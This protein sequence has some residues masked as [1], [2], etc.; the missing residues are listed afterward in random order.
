MKPTKPLN[1]FSLLISGLFLSLTLISSPSKAQSTDPNV[2]F[3]QRVLQ[4]GEDLPQNKKELLVS[5]SEDLSVGND[6]KLQALLL[7]SSSSIHENLIAAL[8]SGDDAENIV[9]LLGVINESDEQFIKFLSALR[10][11]IH[12]DPVKLE[13]VRNNMAIVYTDILATPVRL[14]ALGARLLQTSIL[15]LAI[16]SLAYSNYPD[17][18]ESSLYGD[19]MAFVPYY[20]GMLGMFVLSTANEVRVFFRSWRAYKQSLRQRLV[21]ERHLESF[22]D[23]VK[24]LK[25]APDLLPMIDRMKYFSSPYAENAALQALASYPDRFVNDM[26]YLSENP[27]HW[28]QLSRFFKTREFFRIVKKYDDRL[29]ETDKQTLRRLFREQGHLNELPI[30]IKEEQLNF[31]ENLM[32]EFNQWMETEGHQGF[33]NRYRRLLSRKTQEVEYINDM[34]LPRNAY[35]LMTT[36]LGIGMGILSLIYGVEANIELIGYNQF[37]DSIS[38]FFLS[39]PNFTQYSLASLVVVP[40]TFMA[41]TERRIRRKLKAI[42]ANTH[43]NLSELITLS[44]HLPRWSQRQGLSTPATSG[45]P[46]C[47]NLF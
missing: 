14:P 27:D 19:G 44:Q 31:E 15:N 21:A 23:L 12:D 17:L 38:N 46:M 11:K 26:E 40:I 9:Q 37:F 1:V 47:R 35:G 4:S 25:R 7:E 43:F 5:L 39:H 18:I 41:Y 13:R 22:I 24:G 32:R 29:S 6:S 36:S 20:V 2:A 30:Q 42:K 28:A 34:S 8:L 3:L 10:K 45:A 33:G 16:I